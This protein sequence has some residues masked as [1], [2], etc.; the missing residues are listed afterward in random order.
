[1]VG[2]ATQTSPVGNEWLYKIANNLSAAGS[3][4]NNATAIPIG[5]TMSVFTSV[6][7]GQ[8]CVLPMGVGVGEDYAVANHGVVR[9]WFIPR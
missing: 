1:M 2:M 9:S 7:A 5:Q 6:S 8:G 3:T 4:Q